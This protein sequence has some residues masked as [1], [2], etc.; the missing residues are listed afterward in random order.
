MLSDSSAV[1]VFAETDAHADKIDH[2]ADELPE[3]RKVLRIDSSGPSA[4]DEL[5]EAGASV[6]R[7]RARQQAVGDQGRRSGHADLH[8]GHH[9]SAEG[10]PADA[11]QPGLRDPGRQ[12]GVPDA[13]GQGRAAAGVPAAGARAGPGDHHRAR[14]RNKVTLGFTSDIKNLVPMFGVFKPTLVVSVP[15]VFEKVYNTAEQNA[16]NDG[17]GKIF[18]IAA[19]HRDRVQQGTGRRRARPAARA[20]ARG[21]RP[22]G[23]RQA[24][25]G[26]RRR[27]PRRD[28][29]WRAAGRAAGPLLPRC[30]PDHLRGLRPDRDQ[31]RDHGQ[32]GRRPEGRFG[33]KVVARQQHAHR[34]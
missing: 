9:R 34:R 8:L 24:A 10:L 17:K 6:D 29:R 14:S 1:L 5:T 20:Q 3:L 23:L 15:R 33:R 26:A 18:E 31:R 19:Q 2:L 12:G 11:L 4:L 22:A 30:R 27:L 16:R 13:A 7:G 25:G 28:L 21:V 32:P